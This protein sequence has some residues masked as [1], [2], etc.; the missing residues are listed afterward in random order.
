MNNFK[1]I[2]F[3]IISSATFGLVPL[4]SLIPL[5]AGM[6]SS[7]I[8][9]YRMGFSAVMMGLLNL[10]LRKQFKIPVR[11]LGMVVILGFLYGCTSM[12]LLLSYNYIPTGLA[13]TVHFL[14]PLVVTLSMVFL[15]KETNSIWIFVSIVMSLLGVALMVSSDGT[16]VN[17]SRGLFYVG[18]TVFSYAFYIVGVMKSKASKIDSMVLTFYVLCCASIIFAV[19]SFVTAGQ[20][21]P[22]RDGYLLGDFLLLALLPTVVS[23][24]TL[25]LAIKNIG[26]TMTSILGSMEP[27]TAVLIG[28]L[29]FDEDF[30]WST[31]VGLLLVIISVMIVILQSKKAASKVNNV[32]EVSEDMN[33]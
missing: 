26:S 23:N 32:V 25:I 28:V 10:C 9:F 13:T 3:A 16:A 12:W 7:S 29:H 17:A 1:G 11:S 33:I 2:L 5:Q 15:F 30:T 21:E 6:S 22:I 24:L 20:I 14:Y 19:F 8:L 18:I 27:L 31:L 4:F